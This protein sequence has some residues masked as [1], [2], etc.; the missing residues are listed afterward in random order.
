ML[1][2]ILATLGVCIAQSEGGQLTFFS[3]ENCE[4]PLTWK[5]GGV[6]DIIISNNATGVALTLQFPDTTTSAKS[7]AKRN[8][9]SYKISGGNLAV[10]K[11]VEFTAE[12]LCS[13]LP[14]TWSVHT[15]L[16]T[17]YPVRSVAPTNMIPV[18]VAEEEETSI[19]ALLAEKTSKSEAQQHL[20]YYNGDK[21]ESDL[22]VENPMFNLS[23]Y[24]DLYDW[25]VV[26]NDFVFSSSTAGEGVF[27][28]DVGETIS[29]KLP[30]ATCA[31]LPNW[32]STVD[33][34][35]V[36]SVGVPSTPAP[37]PGKYRTGLKFWQVLIIAAV[38]VALAAGCMACRTEIKKRH[39]GEMY[40]EL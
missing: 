5:E 17:T 29:L 34:I 24:T 26:S 32:L 38:V 33:S 28:L 6:L 19:T 23:T 40:N 25:E 39:G 35:E 10:L 9:S 11:N 14:A 27:L 1:L 12:F 8:T 16:N 2:L 18:T 30:S 7:D 37:M 31:I 13:S 21:C 22:R 4:V 15:H 3:D 20:A 36:G